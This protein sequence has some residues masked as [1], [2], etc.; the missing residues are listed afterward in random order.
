MS[1]S[2][3]ARNIPKEYLGAFKKGHRFSSRDMIDE[4]LSWELLERIE[5]AKKAGKTDKEAEEA[6][7]YIARF[8]NEFHKNVIKK[9]DPEALHNTDELR[10]DCYAREN[11][12]NRDVM[13]VQNREEEV[14][15]QKNSN[16]NDDTFDSTSN[17]E[18]SVYE[19]ISSNNRHTP[20][21]NSTEDAIIELL[22][23]IKLSN[24]PEDPEH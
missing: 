6:L 10:K 3:K 4:E 13:S 11:A 24:T 17:Y 15:T 22:D 19:G 21:I 18:N 23:G 5:K 1:V 2:K 8:N 9:N 14:K 16:F 20:A 7:A 12:K